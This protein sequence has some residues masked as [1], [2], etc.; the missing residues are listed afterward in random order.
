MYAI[1]SYY[2]AEKGA[3]VTGVDFSE[4]SIRYARESAAEKN[5]DI[6]YINMNYLDFRTDVQFDLITMIYCDFCDK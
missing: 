4:R 3:S 5:L 6:D 1:R 2:V